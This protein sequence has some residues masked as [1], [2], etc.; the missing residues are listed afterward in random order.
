MSQWERS[1]ARHK[2]H[3]TDFVSLRGLWGQRLWV[4]KKAT[5]EEQ[6]PQK[7][8]V[9]AHPRDS[10]VS[11]S[12][13]TQPMPWLFPTWESWMPALQVSVCEL[14]C[15]GTL[16]AGTMKAHSSQLWSD[17]ATL[18]LQECSGSPH[19]CGMRTLS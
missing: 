1:L 18:C 19:L 8:G 5:M 15:W 17:W 6:E 7:I 11:C 13:F 3:K 16:K 4:P 2:V 14:G 10:T 9:L 12:D